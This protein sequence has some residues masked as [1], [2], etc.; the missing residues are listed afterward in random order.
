MKEYA[1]VVKTVDYNFENKELDYFRI[2]TKRNDRD[3]ALFLC[4][5][6]GGMHIVS[7][8]EMAE[9][10]WWDRFTCPSCLHEAPWEPK[11]SMDIPKHAKIFYMADG[12]ITVSLTL[13]T[14]RLYIT[15]NDIPIHTKKAYRTRYIFSANGQTYE[16]APVYIASGRPV[17]K[18]SQI[19]TITYEYLKYGAP[20]M[21]TK[22]IKLGLLPENVV[23]RNRFHNVSEETLTMLDNLIRHYGIHA[24]CVLTE[25][26]FNRLISGIKKDMS[27]E[28]VFVYLCRRAQIK[29]TGKKFRQ[30]MAKDTVNTLYATVLYR[31]LKLKDINNFYKIF[32]W[33]QQTGAYHVGQN[34]SSRTFWFLNLLLKYRGENKAIEL[35]MKSSEDLFYDTAYYAKHLLDYLSE[36]EI[37]KMVSG[38]IQK[39]HNTFML[40]TRSIETINRQCNSIDNIIAAA[41]EL[42]N[43]KIKDPAQQIALKRRTINKAEEVTNMPITYSEAEKTLE[44]EGDIQFYLPPDT[45]HLKSAGDE[46]HN[47]VGHCYR[48]AALHKQ[49]LIVLMKQATKLIGCIE[50]ANGRIRQ[51]YGPC[52]HKLEGDAADAYNAWVTKHKMDNHKQN[53]EYDTINHY[54]YR[55][56]NAKYD[57]ALEA[58]I[59][60][61]EKYPFKCIQPQVMTPF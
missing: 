52:N 27:D 15:E 17:H 61:R 5:H 36:E 35:L 10:C 12:S 54:E 37:M 31:K 49:S 24:H 46:L 20:I 4:P 6:C 60:Y 25:K 50:V 18:G 33:I 41:E 3:T 2:V 14:D 48:I 30:C 8:E 23:I 32:K 40:K 16:K 45:D 42:R 51:A 47:C 26:R 34:N 13:V 56:D 22:L 44:E 53:M 28:E 58:L 21:I 7:T 55:I 38:S 39:I 29:G 9:K 11:Y 1:P 59:A 43:G 57:Q 19:R